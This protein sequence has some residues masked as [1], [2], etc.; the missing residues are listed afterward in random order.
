[1][2]TSA[3]DNKHG[4]YDCAHQTENDNTKQREKR[5]DLLVVE[6][7]RHG[8][9]VSASPSISS[10]PTSPQI[11]STFFSVLQVNSKHVNARTTA[12]TQLALSRRSY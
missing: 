8:P 10:P 6:Q 11:K 9:A 2:F 5:I 1:M 7:Q 3:I 4:D 12:T